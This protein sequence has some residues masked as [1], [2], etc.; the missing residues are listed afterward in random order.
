[1]ASSK[2][3]IMKTGLWFK[4]LIYRLNCLRLDKLFKKLIKLVR[5]IPT[6]KL[7]IHQQETSMIKPLTKI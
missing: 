2:I 4:P 1:M 3:K 5:N 7:E 6:T